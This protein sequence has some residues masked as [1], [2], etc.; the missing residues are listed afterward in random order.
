MIYLFDTNIILINIQKKP[1]AFQIREE[2]ALSDPA[3]DVYISVVTIGEIQSLALQNNWGASR[4]S[5]MSQYL[6]SFITLD[7]NVR[8]VIDRYSQID[9]YSQNKLLGRPLGMSARN[10]GKNDL[11]IAATAS[12][13]GAMLVTTDGDFSHLQGPFL[14]LRT[15]SI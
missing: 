7:I 5:L 8:E 4:I 3:N 12:V 13:I 14:A 6:D 1:F 10:M 11:W 2:L 9:A 15:Y